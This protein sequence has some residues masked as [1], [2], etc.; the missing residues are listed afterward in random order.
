MKKVT[1][2]LDSIRMKSI[3]NDYRMLVKA[4]DVAHD[5]AH[6]LTFDL[7][8]L[9]LC[10]SLLEAVPNEEI[11]RRVGQKVWALQQAS[12]LKSEGYSKPDSLLAVQ[13]KAD[14]LAD[15]FNVR[16]AVQHSSFDYLNV[17]IMSLFV[18]EEVPDASV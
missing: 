1:T 11:G 6:A 14:A 7:G 16:E 5:M 12:L 13:A 10:V 9:A 4:G 2:R 8:A 18:V 3:L 17:L 15:P